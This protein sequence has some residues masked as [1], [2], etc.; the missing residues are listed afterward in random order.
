MVAGYQSADACH[1]APRALSDKHSPM[2]FL[3]GKACSLVRRS[4]HLSD[5]TGVLIW[6]KVKLAAS[7]ENHDGNNDAWILSEDDT[8]D[9]TLPF[10]LSLS[11]PYPKRTVHTHEAQWFLM[12]T[13]RPQDLEGPRV[14]LGPAQGRRRPGALAQRER[15]AT[16]VA[17][18]P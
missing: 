4:Y 7:L 6:M 1:H 2:S 5:V 17:G 3:K 14:R 11:A 18:G 13:R 9:L 16:R 15:R 8:D 12:P 10:F